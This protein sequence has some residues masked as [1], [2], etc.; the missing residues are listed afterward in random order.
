MSQI[1]AAAEAAAIPKRVL[2]APTDKLV[3]R[4]KKGEWCLPG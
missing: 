4:T 1:E 2:L 3:V